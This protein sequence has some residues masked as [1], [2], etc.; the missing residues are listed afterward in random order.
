MSET[1]DVITVVN[2]SN[3][4]TS[5]LTQWNPKVLVSRELSER[6]ELNFPPFSRSIVME[7]ESAEATSIVAGF[8]KSLLDKRLPESTRVLGPAQG[9][10]NISRILMTAN[11]SDSDQFLKF[12]GDYI[13]HRAVTKKKSVRLRVDPY[14][15]T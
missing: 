11:L 1:G 2:S 15:L 6:S 5:A 4:I 8:K 10:G 9:S 7:V 14:S 3:P 12:I 13:R